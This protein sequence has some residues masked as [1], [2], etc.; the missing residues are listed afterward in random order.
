MT[1]ANES[2]AVLV[3][4]RAAA[5]RLKNIL[6]R[7][8]I[9]LRIV[10]AHSRKKLLREIKRHKPPMCI[11]EHEVPD[12]DPINWLNREFG[13]VLN[14]LLRRTAATFSKCVTALEL[15]PEMTELSP[16]TKFVITSHW[17][18]FGIPKAEKQLYRDHPAVVKV[19]GF[20]NSYEEWTAKK[21][22]RLYLGKV[23]R[24]DDHFPPEAKSEQR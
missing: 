13:G 21:L 3:C 18:G 15:L 12:A 14:D 5:A 4:G 16:G 20:L 19:L 23:W 24:P 1:Q 7:Y 2:K 22:S 11:V 17:R 9:P 6:E 8:G 10:E